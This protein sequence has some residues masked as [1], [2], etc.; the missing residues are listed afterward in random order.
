[1][2]RFIDKLLIRKWIPDSLIRK[3][4]RK[5]LKNKLQYEEVLF[6]KLHSQKDKKLIQELIESPIAINTQNANEQHYEVP[7][8]FF[9]LVLGDWL[10]YSCG[11]WEN[12][13]NL[14]E[15]E[16]R[17]LD[18]YLARAK[19]I[20]AEDILDLGCGWGSF[21]L[22]AASRFPGK[23]FTAVSNSNSQK[24]FII[25]K[26]K[27]LNIK[28]LKVITTDINSFHPTNKYDRV[29][30]I[31]MFEHMRNYQELFNRIHQWLR[32]D[33]KLFVHIFTHRKYTYKFD[34]VDDSDWM[35]KYFFTGGM[36]PGKNF[37]FHFSKGFSTEKQWEI[38]GMHYSKT[39]EAWLNQMDD[40]ID[41][42]IPIFKESYG[43]EYPKFVAYWR[44]FF[45]ACSE[46]FAMNEGHEWQ[47]HHYLFNKK[48]KSSS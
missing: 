47:V 33:G 24:K 46:T 39:L 36:M 10:K 16:I 35:A 29:I 17:M 34:V 38:N 6:N 26:A 20:D 18:L 11:Y 40:K 41:L 48:A 8:E 30:S 19:I 21:S 32:P 2:R 4:I 5:R 13:S 42:I 22:Y 14:D 15:S 37:L 12:E 25:E 23:N 3:N 43:K 1:M 9:Q 27:I 31:E 7:A 44:I 28:N 45:M